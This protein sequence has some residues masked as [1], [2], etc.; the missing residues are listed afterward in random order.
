MVRGT[1]GE[2]FLPSVVVFTV[3]VVRHHDLPRLQRAWTYDWGLF[4]YS[5]SCFVLGAQ[6]H[7]Y[8]ST[9]ELGR[10]VGELSEKGWVKRDVQRSLPN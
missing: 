10:L 5:T 3:V 7:Y 1:V 8:Y 6:R 4:G 9:R 2:M